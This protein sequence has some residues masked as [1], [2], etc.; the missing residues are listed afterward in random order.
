MK[1]FFFL[2]WC[3]FFAGYLVI[4][5]YGHYYRR[6]VLRHEYAERYRRRYKGPS[7]SKLFFE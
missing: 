4:R 5:S 2:Y 7:Q 1:I 3:T 6:T